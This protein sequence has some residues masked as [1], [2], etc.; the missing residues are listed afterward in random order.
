MQGEIVEILKRFGAKNLDDLR[1]SEV[2]RWLK[3]FA[4]NSETGLIT[5]GGYIEIDSIKEVPNELKTDFK[6]WLS[7]HWD[8]YPN[9]SFKDKPEDF[10]REDHN[11]WGRRL[12]KEIKSYLS[13][14]IKVHLLT[15]DAEDERKFRRNVN[16]EVVT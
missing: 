15:I 3:I 12:A 13:Q 14:E 5:G 6:K 2:S 7:S 9:K 16:R 10:D 11:Q 8:S 1:T 4:A